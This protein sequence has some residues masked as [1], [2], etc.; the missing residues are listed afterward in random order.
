MPTWA[1]S[2]GTRKAAPGAA[3]DDFDL[4][5]TAKVLLFLP[6]GLVL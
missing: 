3:T 6:K 5:E 2:E 1:P 4:L